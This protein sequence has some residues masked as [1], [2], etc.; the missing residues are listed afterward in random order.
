MASNLGSSLREIVLQMRIP[1]IEGTAVIAIGL[2]RADGRPTPHFL[3]RWGGK[4]NANVLTVTMS[5][6]NQWVRL[7]QLRTKEIK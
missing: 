1:M 7:L 2:T 4:V 5:I 3:R 6:C